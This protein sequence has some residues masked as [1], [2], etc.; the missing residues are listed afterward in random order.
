MAPSRAER[1]TRRVDSTYI[2]LSYVSQ[3][4][5]AEPGSQRG[6]VA[7]QET[8]GYLKPHVRWVSRWVPVRA[9]TQ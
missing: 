4:P 3:I 2:T 7:G 5:L 1:T 8:R 6:G 9:S